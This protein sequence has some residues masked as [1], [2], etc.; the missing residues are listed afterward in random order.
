MGYIEDLRSIIGHRPVIFP[1]AVV[2]IVD[3]LGRILMQ[4]RTH[5]KGAWGIPGGLMELGESM[6]DVAKREVREETGLIIDELRLI[7]IFSG[8]QY[9][10]VAENGDEFYTVT[11]AYYT[12]NFS[13]DFRIDKT[14]SIQFQFFY[15]TELPEGIVKTHQIILKEFLQLQN[16]M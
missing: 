12:N 10:T 4:Q 8:A 14:E 15:P 16:D 2:I 9:L 3:D 7:N 11:A 6:E 5:P 1:G 13:G